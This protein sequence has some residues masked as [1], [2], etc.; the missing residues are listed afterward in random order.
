MSRLRWCSVLICF[1]FLV[2]SIVILELCVEYS[3]IYYYRPL[4]VMVST[5]SKSRQSSTTIRT[6]R[7]GM[8]AAATPFPSVVALVTSTLS[9][10][11][12]TRA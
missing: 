2:S 5:L 1:S 9:F 12:E 11:Y 3:V 4:P 10:A 8:E 7:T 6:M